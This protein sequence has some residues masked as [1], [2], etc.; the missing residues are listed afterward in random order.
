METI[1]SYVNFIFDTYKHFVD[2]S[3]KLHRPL[4]PPPSA[5]PGAIWAVAHPATVKQQ[6]RRFQGLSW[7]RKNP[8]KLLRLRRISSVWQFGVVTVVKFN[9][10]RQTPLCQPVRV[11]TFSQSLKQMR[12]Y[13]WW[14]PEARR[15][16]LKKRACYFVPK[17][18]SPRQFILF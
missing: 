13:Q 4:L 3:I 1:C 14:L 15:Y 16:L 12:R 11:I 6:P 5:A 9:N 8:R 18:C 10:K 2:C 17:L 7:L